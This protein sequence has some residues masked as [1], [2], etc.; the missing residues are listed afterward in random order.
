MTPP[1]PATPPKQE[2]PKQ[3]PK[4]VAQKANNW[5]GIDYVRWVDKQYND[6]YDQVLVELDPEKSRALWIQMNDR[7]NEQAASWPLIDRTSV[8]AHA[9]RI[10]SW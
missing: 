6:W 2:P 4:Q 7:V 3:E 9:T 8:S 5:A 1:P 10:R